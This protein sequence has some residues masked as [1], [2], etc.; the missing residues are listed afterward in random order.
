MT[1]QDFFD[2]MKIALEGK[3]TKFE[4][5]ASIN[6]LLAAHSAKKALKSVIYAFGKAAENASTIYQEQ[7][8]QANY[9][10]EL[11]MTHLQL[12]KCEKF[13]KEELNRINDTI[14]EFH[15]YM[16]HGH[17]LYALLG[18]SRKKMD[19]IDYR[20]LMKALKNKKF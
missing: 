9:S 10:L 8:K 3:N 11:Y 12:A 1:E 15:C 18:Y 2:F 7:L 4:L 13:Y 14:D 5:L 17:F 16:F 6:G 19:M 20:I